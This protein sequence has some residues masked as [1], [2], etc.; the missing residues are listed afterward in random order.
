[1]DPITSAPSVAVIFS[2]A[3]Q[4]TVE[5]LD[6]A[7]SFRSRPEAQAAAGAVNKSPSALDAST[8]RLA[9]FVLSV[10]AVAACHGGL[11]K[12]GAINDFM[13]GVIWAVGISAGTDGV[14]SILKYLTY[15][16]ENKKGEAAQ[17]T[18]KAPPAALKAMERK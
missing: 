15:T 9:A 14:N 11:P 6:V 13:Q 4:Q 18:E 1:M 12:L 7:L 8:K 16:K 2:T 17:N 10:I 5:L 3:I